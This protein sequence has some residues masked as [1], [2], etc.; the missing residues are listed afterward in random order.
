M[1]IFPWNENFE[2]GILEI[3][4]QHKVLVKL[5][6]Q[7]A[8][9][10]FSNSHEDVLEET[11]VKLADYAVYHF[12]S[13]EKIWEKFLSEIPDSKMHAET[14]AHFISSITQL[15][16]Q[17]SNTSLSETVEDILLFLTNW[18]A[19]HILGDDMYLG[20]IVLGI[21]SGL[22]MQNAKQKAEEYRT[23]VKQN[24]PL[25]MYDHLCKRT[26][27]LKKEVTN[28]KKAEEKLQLLARV[29]SDTHEGIVIT[30]IKG[31]IVDINPTFIELTGYQ[32]HEV[33]GKNPSILSSGRHSPEFYSDM[34]RAINEHGLWQGELWNCKK[35]GELFAEFLTISALMDE[36][37]KII[38]Y[39]GIFSDITERKEYE[40]NLEKA[41]QAK[42]EF[43]SSMSHELRTPLNAILGFAQ[44]LEMDSET[45]LSEEQKESVDYI[46]SSGQH[47]L[48]L[49][50]D[51][52]ELTAIEAGKTTLTIEPLHLT[53]VINDSVKLLSLLADKANIQIHVLS[54]LELTV[55]A[56]YTKLKQIIINLVT[57]AIKYN[58]EGGS[59]SLDW[60]KSENNTVR[61]SVIDTGIGI[62][63]ANQHKVFG[64]FN[65]LG[66]ENSTIE[67]TG[68]GLVVT[69]D[70]VEMMGGKIG[71]DSI[72]GE[73][74]TFWFELPIT[75]VAEEEL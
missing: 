59:I 15:K 19:H 54:D 43:L 20:K 75:E 71:F 63:E 72:E 21:K 13:E 39:V 48:N 62:S 52:L 60:K 24:T 69:K 1:E 16:E 74:T 68:I 18:L 37:K 32:R 25:A 64:A 40:S 70:L 57:N 45:P 6:N 22:S 56:D 49:I 5:I 9:Y 27:E 66:K 11:F 42:S 12:Q 26:I 14:H 53:D 47:L 50:N 46:L 38:N 61:I 73:G 51:V 8:S 36:D 3:D 10:L 58:R 34:W 29:F 2:V 33:I 30:D 28:R 35:D 55:N 7:L 17:N 4:E 31:T 41:S 23:K 67:G 65:R 44:L